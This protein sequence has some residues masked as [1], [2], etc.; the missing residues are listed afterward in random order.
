MPEVNRVVRGTVY[1]VVRGIV[2]SVD[3]SLWESGVCI[4]FAR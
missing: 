4:S 3:R 2:N 1:T